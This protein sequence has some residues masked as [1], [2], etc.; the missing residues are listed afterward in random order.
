DWKLSLQP[1][2]LDHPGRSRKVE[3]ECDAQFGEHVVGGST[4]VITLQAVV[5]LDSVHPAHHRAAGQDAFDALAGW[6][7]STQP[8]EHDPRVE[9]D[10]HRGS[11]VRSWSSRPAIPLVA[12]RPPKRVCGCRG[13]R[14]M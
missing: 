3:V 12:N 2:R 13:R 14:T 9:A 1:S 7:L 8:G 10:G 4:P 11:A 5:H 6:R